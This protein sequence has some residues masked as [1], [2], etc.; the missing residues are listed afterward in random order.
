MGSNESSPVRYRFETLID[1]LTTLDT[2]EIEHLEVSDERTIVIYNRSILNLE[3][4]DGQLDDAQTILVEIFD[5]SPAASTDYL[6]FVETFVEELT[7]ASDV[8]W[9]RR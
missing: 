9:E 5:P 3:V 8:D 1:V 4:V 6:R 2:Q 7:T